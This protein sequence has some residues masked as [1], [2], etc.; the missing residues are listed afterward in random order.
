MPIANN[1]FSAIAVANNYFSK[2]RMS[3]RAHLTTEPEILHRIVKY[4]YLHAG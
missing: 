2:E 1:Y 3:A 4:I